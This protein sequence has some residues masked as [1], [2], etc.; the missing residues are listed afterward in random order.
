MVD[1]PQ[2]EPTMTVNHLLL[3]ASLFA[4]GCGEKSDEERL[5]DLEAACADY[6]EGYS[7]L[8]DDW[9]RTLASPAPSSVN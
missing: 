8:Q 1:S 4:V 2:M 5:D 9:S 3:V 6:L 7:R